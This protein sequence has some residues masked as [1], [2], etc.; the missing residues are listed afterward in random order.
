MH[1]C[2]S[3]CSQLAFRFFPPNNVCVHLEMGKAIS[4]LLIQTLF[5][6]L[7]KDEKIGDSC[8]MKGKGWRMENQ[9]CNTTQSGLVKYVV[10]IAKKERK[11]QFSCHF[12]LF[13]FTMLL[14][15]I[16]FLF[17]P[18]PIHYHSRCSDY[19]IFQSSQKQVRK[20]RQEKDRTGR[21]E[22][23]LTYY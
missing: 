11:S 12:S 9:V 8:F 14:E 16:L 2:G 6:Y 20:K 13:M 23:S 19:V 22:S 21:R 7:P 15:A 3:N 18:L 4:V 10:N 5:L 1:F 17:S